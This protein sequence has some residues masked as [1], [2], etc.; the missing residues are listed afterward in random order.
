MFFAYQ[1]QH[2][3]DQKK[4]KNEHNRIGLRWWN[5]IELNRTETTTKTNENHFWIFNTKKPKMHIDSIRHS[6]NYC[7]WE[8]D[9]KYEKN[10]VIASCEF[11]RKNVSALFGLVAYCCCRRA[12]FFCVTLPLIDHIFTFSAILPHFADLIQ[13]CCFTLSCM[14]PPLHSATFLYDFVVNMQRKMFWKTKQNTT[15]KMQ[16]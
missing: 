11:I 12:V 2:R 4:Q 8:E 6:W 13:C 9:R 1:I 16:Y 15:T 10:A 14:D 3:I 7:A 5:F